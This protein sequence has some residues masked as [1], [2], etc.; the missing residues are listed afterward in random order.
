MARGTNSIF[1]DFQVSTKNLEK[2]EGEGALSGGT[3]HHQ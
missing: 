3:I 2:K 1:E